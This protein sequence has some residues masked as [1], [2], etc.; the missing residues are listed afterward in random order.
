MDR[1]GYSRIRLRST[2]QLRRLESKFVRFASF[3]PQAFTDWTIIF[4]GSCMP[5]G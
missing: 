4:G 3:R 2:Q 5:N 1:R